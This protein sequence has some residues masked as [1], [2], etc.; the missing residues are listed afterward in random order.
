MTA[1][2]FCAV[3]SRML[4]MLV[5]LLLP[6]AIAGPS[7]GSGE[8]TD[9]V[10]AAINA[11]AT[12]IQS[13]RF[14]VHTETVPVGPN[15]ASPTENVDEELVL[16]GVRSRLQR[17]VTRPNEPTDSPRRLQTGL[18]VFDGEK[19][20]HDDSG[21]REVGQGART[22][23]PESLSQ[24]P[25]LL[26]LPAGLLQPAVERAVCQTPPLGDALRDVYK[27]QQ[28]GEETV[29]GLSCLR[30]VG[31][32]E[33]DGRVEL[34]RSW[35]VAPEKGYAVV[36]RSQEITWTPPGRVS[37]KKTVDTVEKWMQAADGFWLPEVTVTRWYLQPTGAAAPELQ[38]IDT[39]TLL[40][41]AVN[42]PVSDEAFG[43]ES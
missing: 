10:L 15:S 7:V 42:I 43:T 23:V 38:R 12:H 26:S 6:L 35:W 20:L 22:I 32:V 17:T 24:L 14:L 2:G 4:A 11:Y 31:A 39:A 19:I 40:S 8:A 9:G 3:A 34:V 25:T 18:F 16:D 37:F 30:F 13:G 41:S 36:Q 21:D 5:L 33:K 1:K 27:A 28:V 29:S